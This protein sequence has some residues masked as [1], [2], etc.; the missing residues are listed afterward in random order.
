MCVHCQ[1]QQSSP[2]RLLE[3]KPALGLVQ[4]TGEHQVPSLTS[5]L[6]RHVSRLEHARC[7]RVVLLGSDRI[8][9]GRVGSD[10]VELHGVG[11]AGVGWS[12]MRWDRMGR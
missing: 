4:P 1:S 3:L 2:P 11:L 12:R 10:W 6:G 8:E 5:K 7:I 9:S